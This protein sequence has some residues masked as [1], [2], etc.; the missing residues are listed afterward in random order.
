MCTVFDLVGPTLLWQNGR[1]FRGV[2]FI[3]W[4]HLN[5]CVLQSETG[6]ESSFHFTRVGDNLTF[7]EH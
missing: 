1:I 6:L 7:F 4:D 3:Q 2:L 5:S